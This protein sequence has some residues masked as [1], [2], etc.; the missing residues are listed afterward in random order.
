M[1]PRANNGMGWMEGEEDDAVSWSRNNNNHEGE[2][3][4]ADLNHPSLSTFK[5]FLESDWYMNNAIIMNPDFQT[6]PEFKDMNMNMNMTFSS[7]SSS[8]PPT[9]V[10]ADNLLL[11]QPKPMD[12]SSSCSPSQ[13]FN[14]DPSLSHPF[15]PPPS[16]C[17]SSLFNVVCNNNNNPFENGFDLGCD[18]NFLENHNCN[19]PML[20]GFNGPSWSSSEFPATRL[21]QIS[22]NNAAIGFEGLRFCGL[23]EILQPV[24]TQPTLFQKRAALR[25]SSAAGAINLG[26]LD[27]RRGTEVSARADGNWGKRLDDGELEKKRKINDEDEFEE[28][29]IDASGLNYD[30]SDEPFENKVVES[31]DTNNG[32]N[33]N[34]NANTTVTTVVVGDDQ[35]EK[36]KKKGL[37][38]KNLMAER[39]RRKKLNDRLYM[40]RSVVPKISKMDRASILG[41]AIE[42]LKE[43]LQR[44]NDL[45]NELEATPL[46]P[47]SLL[48]LPPT[49]SFHP[50][51]PTP[52]TL[53]YRI[54]EELCPSSLPSPK[55]QPARVEVRVREGR[56]VN[57]HM[58]C[59]RRP[60]L[61]LSTMRALD[62]LGLDI[63]QAVISCFNGFALDVFIA[64]QCREGLE[65][66]PEQIKA[67]LLDSAGFQL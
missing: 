27:L 52:P 6:I 18:T 1:R 32:G 22:D 31:E 14:F 36:G 41:D 9:T 26:N 23:L 40:L 17:F 55:N 54:K 37:P 30:S 28:A 38:A 58:F 63:Q 47:G 4:D 7:S 64:E 42:Y 34:S 49:S 3:T 44:I 24:G 46:A 13:T 61:L 20:M 62:N 66:V 19:S 25:Q 2:T 15:L 8:N 50:L 10:P 56:A 65:V 39:R 33:N 43:L 11:Q 48:P 12:S 16:S 53:P 60:G 35:K 21:V 67:V 59:A 57:I 45:H 5:S 51:T 29:S